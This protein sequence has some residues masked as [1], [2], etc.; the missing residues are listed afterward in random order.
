MFILFV[1]GEIMK[2]EDIV[3]DRT[4]GAMNYRRYHFRV[5]GET[6]A[7]LTARYARDSELHEVTFDI[8]DGMCCIWRKLGS[9]NVRV[10]SPDREL[11]SLLQSI[12]F[13]IE[14]TQRK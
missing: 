13:E 8:Q 1:W 14:R 10:L 2:K 12:V 3:F 6:K 5:D 11:N 7:E 9:C 4:T